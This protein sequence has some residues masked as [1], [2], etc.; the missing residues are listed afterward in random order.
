MKDKVLVITNP[1]LIDPLAF[2][3]IGAST[4]R[5]DAQTIGFFGSGLKYAIAG[6]LRRGIHF[7]VWRGEELLE[8]TT[9]EVKLRDQSF[10]RILFNGVPT[11]LTTDMGPR[12]EKWMLIRELYANSIDE[13]GEM[14]V[15]E[16]YQEFITPNRTT[17]I[18]PDID[19]VS[20]VISDQDVLFCRGR[21]IEY[22]DDTLRIYE[23][24]GD[25]G[26]YVKG[27]LVY[28][29]LAGFGYMQKSN[30]YTLNE[31]R[32]LASPSD[33]IRSTVASI[34]AINDRKMVKRIVA[35]AKAKS[36]I[37]NSLFQTWLINHHKAS[38]AWGD[39][40]LFK[41]VSADFATEWNHLVVSDDV[42]N[43]TENIQKWEDR[44]W[45]R[46]G[47]PAQMDRLRLSVDMV[48]KA[49]PG[50]LPKCEWHFGSSISRTIGMGMEGGT[51][52]VS[53]GLADEPVH[54]IA[55]HIA[56]SMCKE[57]GGDVKIMSRYF[58]V[59]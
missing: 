27:I 14:A 19:Q 12:W 38:E 16:D 13:G 30:P 43:Y 52:F 29:A 35:R 2:E 32:Q 24:V 1:G 44:K 9:Q 10:Q 55:A 58:Q 8:I 41:A 23:E 22:E 37:E 26:F 15:T 17:I 25:G 46:S 3:L 50:E 56:L 7:Q 59:Q 48:D 21:E 54:I 28:R 49:A 18:L 57:S 6:L 51:M 42:Y 5:S 39:I 36:T 31:E 47:T 34:F 53:D 20:D 11:S 4:K 45:K 33:A 40:V